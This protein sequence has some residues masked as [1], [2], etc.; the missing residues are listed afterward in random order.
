MVKGERSEPM[1]GAA[2][3]PGVRGGAKHHGIWPEGGDDR[4][5]GQRTLG[6]RRYSYSYSYSYSYG[7]SG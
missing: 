5:R 6:T 4:P 2:E 3:R 1:N 7:Y